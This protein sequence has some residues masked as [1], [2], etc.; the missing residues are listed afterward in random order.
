MTK[1]LVHLP[2]DLFERLHREADAR[3]LP[4]EEAALAALRRGLGEPSDRTLS[5]EDLMERFICESGLF[6]A[7]D[8]KLGGELERRAKD[9]PPEERERLAEVLSRGKSPS[10]M[11]IED[12]G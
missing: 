5:D 3:K 8:Q 11:I 12:R 6:A 1:L 2:D 10:E 4:L 9:M 7:P